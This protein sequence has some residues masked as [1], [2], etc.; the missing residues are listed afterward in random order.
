MNADLGITHAVYEPRNTI[1]ADRRN[2]T[3]GWGWE[4]G[5][6]F[7]MGERLREGAWHPASQPMPSDVLS[8]LS[9]AAS[10]G[11]RL[12]AYVYPVLKFE[13]LSNAWLG[14]AINLAAPGAK[15][16]VASTLITFGKAADVG[17]G[18]G[19]FAWDHDI[20]AGGPDLLYSQWRAWMW[21]LKQLRAALPNIIMDHRQTN[22]MW[23]P[24]YQLAGSYAEPIA[25]DENPETC[26][27]T[28]DSG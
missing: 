2:S 10:K 16:W 26:T 3:D 9:L 8:M 4:A 21:V 17:G 5:L 11:V 18:F 6:W 27:H 7:S 20:F 14:G 15:E 24:W 19:G 23:G 12:L 22:H 25:G 1:H 13:A 28:H